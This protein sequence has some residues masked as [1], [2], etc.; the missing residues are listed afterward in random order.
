[1][2]NVDAVTNQICTLICQALTLKRCFKCGSLEH[3]SNSSACPKKFNADGH[4]VRSR[5]PRRRNRSR[6]RDRGDGD[7][8]L[9]MLLALSQA[10]AHPP[11]SALA[12]S[13]AL[14]LSRS[15]ALS[16]THAPTRPTRTS[17]SRS[18]HVACSLSR[19]LSRTHL[20][21]LSLSLHCALLVWHCQSTHSTLPPCTLTRAKL[22]MPTRTSRTTS[23]ALACTRAGLTSGASYRF[24]SFMTHPLAILFAVFS[25]T[26]KDVACSVGFFFDPIFLPYT[27]FFD[28]T[29]PRQTT[30]LRL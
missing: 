6:E 7:R 17:L 3:V 27:P 19:S 4:R 14:S 29:R 15:R 23:R 2:S 28:L 11:L 26:L 24:S 16:S 25:S 13:V 5:S 9:S 20:S 10:H 21:L 1:M 18:L 30:D 12:L 8:D 22:A